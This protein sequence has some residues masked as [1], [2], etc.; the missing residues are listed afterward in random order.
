MEF[1]IKIGGGE[2]TGNIFVMS[3]QYRFNIQSTG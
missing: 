3:G 1:K 2:T